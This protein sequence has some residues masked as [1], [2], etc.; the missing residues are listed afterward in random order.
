MPFRAPIYL[1]QIIS[2]GNCNFVDILLAVPQWHCK[3]YSNH[4]MDMYFLFVVVAVPPTCIQQT[5]LQAWLHLDPEQWF[6]LTLLW[7]LFWLCFAMALR[8][9]HGAQFGFNY[10]LCST[11]NIHTSNAIHSDACP[12]SI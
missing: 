5:Y 2:I 7:L 6:C 3:Q 4:S 11:Y 10:Q 1:Q 8:S 9:V 12:H